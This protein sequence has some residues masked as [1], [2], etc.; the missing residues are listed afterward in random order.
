MCAV[1]QIVRQR[2]CKRGNFGLLDT[3]CAVEAPAG[4]V[5]ARLWLA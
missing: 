2:E 3:I 1:L 4:C 5:E